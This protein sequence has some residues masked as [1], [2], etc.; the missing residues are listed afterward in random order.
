M[1]SLSLLFNLRGKGVIWDMR[2]VIIM[3]KSIEWV[4]S[5]SL[6]ASCERIWVS[7]AFLS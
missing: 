6:S 2:C 7:C 4:A 1:G 5:W 3:L